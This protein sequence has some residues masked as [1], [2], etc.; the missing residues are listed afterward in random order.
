MYS[1]YD[2]WD[3]RNKKST[4]KKASHNNW[5]EKCDAGQLK[6]LCKASGVPVSGTKALLCGRLC[7]GELS[8]KYA[9]EYAP[10]RFS[11]ARWFENEHIGYGSG[12]ECN[13]GRIGLYPAQRG[14]KRASAFSN[15]CLK[16]MC[17]EKGLAYSGKRFDLVLNLLKNESGKGGTPK[18]AAGSFDDDGN[19]QP[20]KRAKS[21]A[22]P[23]IEKIKERAFKKICPSD[24][25]TRKWSNNKHKYHPVEC[26]N[27]ASDT[28]EKEIFGKELFERG[29]VKLAWEVIDA[30]LHHIIRGDQE[31]ER[32]YYAE[33][34]ASG[35]MVFAICTKPG[36]G[37]AQFE[38]TSKLFPNLIKAVEAT[39]GEK[40]REFGEEILRTLEKEAKAYSID[41]ETFSATLDK[42]IPCLKDL[43]PKV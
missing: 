31:R 39:N 3:G 20:K 27:F 23:N 13:Q 9:F 17:R 22:L 1:I 7:N 16:T 10:E 5:F 38:V 32:A 34:S 11:R 25:T 4:K 42:K 24:E 40:L 21:M 6:Q 18:T 14:S 8:E 33:A 41:D 30:V 19:F 26:V 28:I 12:D 29:E 37:R 36:L 43:S 2:S 15:D 35:G